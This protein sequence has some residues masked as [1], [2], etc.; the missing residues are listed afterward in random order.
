MCRLLFVRS[1]EPFDTASYLE[2]F[3]RICKN[4]KEYQGHGWGCAWPEGGG[5]KNYRNVRPIWEDDLGPF[6]DTRMLLAHAR[7]AFRNEGIAV[8]NN[9]PFT[10]GKTVFLFNGELA[11]VRLRAEGR[12]GAE[13]V[14]NVIRR[15]DR[16]D[17]LSAL[18]Q[19]VRL[20]ERRTRY[21]KAMN[22][23]L[24]D[25]EYAWA[26]SLFSEDPDYFTLHRK[27]TGGIRIICSE[28]FPGETGWE[29]VPNRFIGEI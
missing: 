9:M 3:A 14:Y 19:A 12:I 1:P 16:G 4:S 2:P 6:P 21:V 23:I 18:R 29:P 24:S 22:I 11:G 15:L 27:E 8:E 7:S 10:D 17:T 25:G 13:K 5:W 26:S 20:I 28:P